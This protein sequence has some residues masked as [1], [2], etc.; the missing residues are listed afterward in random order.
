MNDHAGGQCSK[1]N[2]G[3]GNVT[4]EGIPGEANVSRGHTGHSHTKEQ[5]THSQTKGDIRGHRG[6]RAGGWGKESRAGLGPSNRK[7]QELWG[8]RW[9]GTESWRRLCTMN[10]TYG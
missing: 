8:S 3:W 4:S 10:R 1:G 2:L 9:E 5:N 6:A 7:K